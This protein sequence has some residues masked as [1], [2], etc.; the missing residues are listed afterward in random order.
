MEGSIVATV[1]AMEGKF[2]PINVEHNLF[3]GVGREWFAV[4]KL[5]FGLISGCLSHI[6]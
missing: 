2:N 5:F 3:H 4:C 1:D 6:T